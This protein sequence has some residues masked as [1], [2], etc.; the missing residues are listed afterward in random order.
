MLKISWKFE[1]PGDVVVALNVEV[2]ASSAGRRLQKRTDEGMNEAL[3]GRW[4]AFR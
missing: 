2:M 4:Q 3:V 1:G